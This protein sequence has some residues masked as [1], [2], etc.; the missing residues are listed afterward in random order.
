MFG[1]LVP[2][3]KRCSPADSA[4]KFS[5]APWAKAGGAIAKERAFPFPSKPFR[6]SGEQGIGQL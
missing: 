1:R 4:K 5:F 2:G 3:S 6:L